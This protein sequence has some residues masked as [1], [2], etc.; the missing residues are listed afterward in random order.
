MRYEMNTPDENISKW[1]RN[2]MTLHKWLDD[3]NKLRDCYFPNYEKR[4]FIWNSCELY[5]NKHLWI[6][7][8]QGNISV[9]WYFLTCVKFQSATRAHWFEAS[10]KSTKRE[11]ITFFQ[12]NIEIIISYS[13]PPE[14]FNQIYGLMYNRACEL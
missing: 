4:L 11:A 9:K 13:Y 8:I 1:D 14:Y 10:S 7:N 5:I 2:Y 3:E 12:I 6:T